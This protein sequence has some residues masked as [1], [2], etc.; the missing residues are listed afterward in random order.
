MIHVIW[1][2][3]VSNHIKKPQQVALS[4]KTLFAFFWKETE[5]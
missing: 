5:L 1:N 4:V 2:S 3:A